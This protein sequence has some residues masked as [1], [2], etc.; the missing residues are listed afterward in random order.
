MPLCL[1]STGEL[2]SLNANFCTSME[3]SKYDFLS[4]QNWSAGYISQIQ[5]YTRDPYEAPRLE[6]VPNM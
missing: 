1:N 3:Q 5:K 2:L 4:I 6:K